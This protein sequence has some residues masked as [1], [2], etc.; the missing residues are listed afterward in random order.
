MAKSNRSNRTKKNEKANIASIVLLSVVILLVFWLILSVAFELPFLDFIKDDPTNT[1]GGQP[2]S[3]HTP[4]PATPTPTHSG[5]EPTPT[6]VTGE[7][8]AAPTPDSTTDVPQTVKCYLFAYK[9]GTAAYNESYDYSYTGTLDKQAL[10]RD[11]LNKLPSF[12]NYN[13]RYNTIILDENGIHI[14]LS[15]DGSPFVK[16]SYYLS[17]GVHPVEYTTYDQ[18][19][20]GILDS[21]CY[22]A[23]D[24]LGSNTGVYITMDGKAM[25]FTGLTMNTQFS[26]ET[27]YLGYTY[28]HE[29]Y[30]TGTDIYAEAMN[31]GVALTFAA[32]VKY[33][34]RGT[35]GANT[36]DVTLTA[37]PSTGM[38]IVKIMSQEDTPMYIFN[39]DSNRVLLSDPEDTTVNAVLYQKADNSL[40]GEW[41]TIIGGST[42]VD[43]VQL[44]F[45]NYEVYQ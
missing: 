36:V 25:S 10:A 42:T 40:V 38:V 26:A 18:Q 14:D 43:K 3:T 21:I 7:P 11:C 24:C 9:D 2:V 12:L 5:D 17:T 19:V 30:E 45:M 41:Q 23:K 34:Y 29:H 27:P 20:Y 31:N 32:N 35:I 1:T 28:Y 15:S 37:T 44:T 22:T 6:P 16:D 39:V 4:E 33:Y 13:L 8:T